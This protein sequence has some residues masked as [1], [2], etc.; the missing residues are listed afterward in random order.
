MLLFHA[1]I[2]SAM[3]SNDL[4]QIQFGH[5]GAQ[6][7]FILGLAI[8]ANCQFAPACPPRQSKQQIFN[9]LK[10][11]QAADVQQPQTVS[12]AILYGTRFRNVYTVTKDQGTG[13]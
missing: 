8:P 7:H 3:K 6:T 2:D 12:P 11:V 9:S 1:A 13:F 5:E 10:R 4:L